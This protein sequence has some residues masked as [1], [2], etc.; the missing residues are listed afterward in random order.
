MK[1]LFSIKKTIFLDNPI[2][3]RTL[4]PGHTYIFFLNNT[5]HGK[6]YKQPSFHGLSVDED[7]TIEVLKR[8]CGL[9]TRSFHPVSGDVKPEGINE[10]HIVSIGCE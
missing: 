9:Q 4:V 2:C 5:K 3:F 1:I 6:F 7:T 8:T 10:C